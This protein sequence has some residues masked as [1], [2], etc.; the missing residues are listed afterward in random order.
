MPN[1]QRM[2]RTPRAASKVSLHCRV[3]GHELDNRMVAD[4]R[5]RCRGCHEPIL[6]EDGRIT[7]TRHVLGCMLRHHTYVRIDRRAGHNE[8]L[9]LRCGHPLLLKDRDPHSDALPFH[10]RV[11]YRCAAFG[12][13]FTRSRP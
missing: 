5:P 11:H 10:K 9:C 3:L 6:F 1:P 2:S 12:H 4:G 8:Y 13:S 7:H